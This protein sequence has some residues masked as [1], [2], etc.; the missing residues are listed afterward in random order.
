MSKIPAVNDTSI[1]FSAS[2]TISDPTV[3]SEN[4]LTPPVY[5]LF[6]FIAGIVVL[7]MIVIP[8]II[9]IILKRH[10]KSTEES[11]QDVYEISNQ[12]CGQFNKDRP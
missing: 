12:T 4:S 6:G 7:I 1:V 9:I 3:M 8:A 5:F 11:V 2:A 10:Q